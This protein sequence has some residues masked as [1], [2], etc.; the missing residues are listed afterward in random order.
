LRE[1]FIRRNCSQREIE[2]LAG[3]YRGNPVVVPIFSKRIFVPSEGAFR[4]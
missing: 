4:R 1:P 2:V 3:C